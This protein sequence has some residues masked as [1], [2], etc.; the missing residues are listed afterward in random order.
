M[1]AI[2]RSLA[3]Q[4]EETLPAMLLALHSLRRLFHPCCWL[5][6]CA[7]F[8]GELNLPQHFSHSTFAQTAARVCRCT[9]DLLSWIGVMNLCH[10]LGVMEGRKTRHL[11]HPTKINTGL[12]WYMPPL[13][14]FTFSFL[15]QISQG[16]ERTFSLTDRHINSKCKSWSSSPFITRKIPVLV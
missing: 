6:T 16:A 12:S 7:M 11:K 3:P 9:S 2:K 5:S 13:F 8:P 14:F 4:F 1:P 15:V 10:G